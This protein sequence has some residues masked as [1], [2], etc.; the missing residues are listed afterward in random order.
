MCHFT[1]LVNYFE[2]HAC[3]KLCCFISNNSAVIPANLYNLPVI[4]ANL[5]SGILVVNAL[6]KRFPIKAFGND[7]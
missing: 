6:T 7:M 5:L 1:L 4:P 3:F 2:I